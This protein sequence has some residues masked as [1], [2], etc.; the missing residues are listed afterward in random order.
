MKQLN[1]F[2]GPNEIIYAAR[3]RA[4]QAGLY[5]IGAGVQLY[6]HVCVCT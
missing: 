6:I 5:V 2:L 3:T 1:L 4:A